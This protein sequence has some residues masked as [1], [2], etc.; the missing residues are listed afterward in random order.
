MAEL[1]RKAHIDRAGIRDNAVPDEI[2][3]AL[4][5]GTADLLRDRTED[6]GD[7]LKEAKARLEAHLAEK[8]ASER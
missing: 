1:R 7:F 5:T 6:I 2:A 4:D 3:R 8:A